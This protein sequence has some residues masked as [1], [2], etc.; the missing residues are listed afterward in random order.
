MESVNRCGDCGKFCTKR[1]D[2]PARGGPGALYNGRA[3]A[4]E[5]YEYEYKGITASFP[6]SDPSVSVVIST[7]GMELG[8]GRGENPASQETITATGTPGHDQSKR[9]R[10]EVEESARDFSEVLD[11]LV[12]IKGEPETLEEAYGL[13]SKA[14]ECVMWI[15]HQDY[16]A[17]NIS[18]DGQLG[19]A[20]RAGDKLARIKN[21]LKTGNKAKGEPRE[22]AWGDLANYGKIGVLLER[23]WWD[24]PAECLEVK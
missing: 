14:A 17:K 2:T 12:E 5:G 9:L 19:V 11:I 20:I 3:F 10:Q 24:L 23:G 7:E 21:L 1:C 22:D 16:G 6:G 18:E 13:V 8:Q 15:R 4:C